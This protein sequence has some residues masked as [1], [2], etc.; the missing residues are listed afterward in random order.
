MKQLTLQTNKIKQDDLN[1]DLSFI[2]FTASY[3]I[4]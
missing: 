2:C 1:S 3:I 4:I